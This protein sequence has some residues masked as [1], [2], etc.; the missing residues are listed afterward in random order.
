MEYQPSG[1][2]EPDRTAELRYDEIDEAV[3]LYVLSLFLN[4][5]KNRYFERDQVEYNPVT[6]VLRIAVTIWE[7]VAGTPRQRVD[8]LVA[9]AKPSAKRYG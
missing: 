7:D 5:D 6:K 2:F 9:A 3:Y 8:Q 4:V 1:D